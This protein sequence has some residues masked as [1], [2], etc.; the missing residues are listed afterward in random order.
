MEHDRPRWRIRLST[1]M[2]LV[3]IAALSL[4]L[5][6]ERRRRDVALLDALRASQRLQA[7]ALRA[8]VSGGTTPASAQQGTPKTGQ[9]TE[10][11]PRRGVWVQVPPSVLRRKEAHRRAGER[12]K[13]WILRA[14]RSIPI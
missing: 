4:T 8:Q 11:G 10:S 7:Q 13:A 5:V 6:Y 2:P 3:I 9:K 12:Q 1:L 14:K